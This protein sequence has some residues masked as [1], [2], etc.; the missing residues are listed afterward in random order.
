MLDVR[1]ELL[2]DFPREWAQNTRV[3]FHLGASE[4]I[5]RLVLLEGDAV[6]AGGSALAQLRLE[7]PTVAARGDRFV[8]RS[9]SPSRTAGG[10]SVIE[11]LA[12]RRGRHAA[13]AALEQLAVHESGSLEARVIEKLAAFAK[14]A[15]T[16]QVAQAMGEPVAAVSAALASLAKEDEIA[17]PAESRWLSLARWTASRD[18]IERAVREYLEKFPARYGVMKGELK[19]GLKATMDP[20][21]FDA[22]FESL[23]SDRALEQRGE[24]VRLGGLPWEA[25][26]EMLAL[27]ESVERELEAAG[28][29]V[30]ENAA[31]QAKLGANAAEVAA[32]GFFLE[33]LVR[34]T[35]EYTYTAAQ[36]AR[37]RALL[38]GFF[39]KKPALTVAD[40][41]ELAAVSRKWAVPLLEHCDRVGWT[42]RVGDE[43]RSGSIA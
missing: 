35:Q 40:F 7:R 5:G 18:S 28:F 30:P 10:G 29:S 23:V 19:N 36:L 26:A 43:R 41:R 13:G 21:L 1:F 11:P 17:A 15:S 6:R 25:P 31:W 3:R 32:L 20:A 22:A 37:L 42:V 27:L 33:R 34:V 8:I 4:I 24:R 12:A 2:A 14:P 16:E 38:A 9:Y 39:A